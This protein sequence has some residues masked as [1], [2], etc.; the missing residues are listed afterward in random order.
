MSRHTPIQ[1]EPIDSLDAVF[2]A[3][4]R[5]VQQRLGQAEARVNRLRDEH[6]R[7]ALMEWDV[8]IAIGATLGYAGKG[9]HPR[10]DS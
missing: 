3:Q 9:Y 2:Q 1:P 7:Y 4:I 6:R 5:R 10:E 8:D